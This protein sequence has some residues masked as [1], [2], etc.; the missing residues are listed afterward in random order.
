MR[1]KKG[2]LVV[3][4]DTAYGLVPG[5]IG[6]VLNPKIRKQRHGGVVAEV[7][8]QD[9]NDLEH[10]KKE[11]ILVVNVYL[12]VRDKEKTTYRHISERGRIGK[13]VFK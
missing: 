13:L 4:P 3:R 1:L 10:N 2:D 7:Y 6:I 5:I 8:W 12:V 9:P 11:Q